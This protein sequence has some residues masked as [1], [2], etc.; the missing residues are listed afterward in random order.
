MHRGA[1]PPITPLPTPEITFI[2]ISLNL[3]YLSS[4]IPE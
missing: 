2:P 4:S 1:I 3:M